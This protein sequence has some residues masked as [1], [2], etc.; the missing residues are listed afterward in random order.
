MSSEVIG[1]YFAGMFIFRIFPDVVVA[2]VFDTVRS[3]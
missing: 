1:L 3:T 2:V